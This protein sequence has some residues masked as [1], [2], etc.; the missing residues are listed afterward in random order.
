MEIIFIKRDPLYTAQSIYKA[1][2]RLKISQDKWW[3]IKPKN[4]LELENLPA[5]EQIV[6]QIF[7]LEKQIMNDSKLFENS[8]FMVIDYAQIGTQTS[9][10]NNEIDRFLGPDIVKRKNDL[11]P[12]FE[13]SEEQ[14]LPNELFENFKTEVNKYDWDNYEIK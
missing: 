7:Y 9:K 2:E 11:D 10:F 8:N 12:N 4:Y 3:S 14:K 1:K 6:K 13:F 5:V